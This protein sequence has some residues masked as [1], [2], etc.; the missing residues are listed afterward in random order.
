MPSPSALPFGISPLACFK[1]YLGFVLI[2]SGKVIDVGTTA[3]E[4][5]VYCLEFPRGGGTPRHTGPH[6]EAPGLVKRQGEREAG[7]EAYCGF[8]E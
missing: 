3:F 5:R 4:R 1:I 2:R 8:Q 6:G 7:Q